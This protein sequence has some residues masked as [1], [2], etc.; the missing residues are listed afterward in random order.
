MTNYVSPCNHPESYLSGSTIESM[1]D[2]T[3]DLGLEYFACTDN[4][5][6]TSVLKAISYGK[7]KG[8]KVIPGVELFFKDNE[9]EIIQN[10]P[11]EA[12]KYFKIVVHA[13]DQEAYQEIVRQCSDQ[14][15]KRVRVGEEEYPL[16]TWKDLEQIS[17][18]NTTVSTSNVECMVSKHLLVGNGKACEAYYLKL[19]DLF[20]AENFYPAIIPFAYDKY[21]NKMMR[22]N[23]GGKVVEIPANDRVIT[24][25]KYFKNYA[26][27]LARRGHTKLK[28]VFINKVKYN[29]KKEFQDIQKVES[30]Y[31]F[32]DLP[33]DIQAQANLLIFALAKRHGDMDRLLI[34]NYAYYA[35]KDDKVVQD[36][37]LGEEKRMYQA[38]Y[39]AGIESVKEYLTVK[40]G[41][42]SE[43]LE[44]LV[45]NS[46][47][48]AKQFDN[49][50]LKYDYR[51]VDPGVEPEKQLIEIVK[52]NGR[53][54]WDDPVYLKQF[55][56]EFEL[57]T[58]NGVI[59][60]VPYFLPI[61]DVYDFYKNNGYLTGPARGC[62][63]GET[64]VYTDKG[65]K[66]LKDVEIGDK[67]ISHTGNY[68]TVLQRMRYDVSD[69]DLLHISAYYG[70]DGIKLTKDHKLL[71][72]KK[73]DMVLH[74]DGTIDY[75]KNDLNDESLRKWD[76]A[77]NF[78]VG[79]LLF[80]PWV[81]DREVKDIDFFDLGDFFTIKDDDFV[82]SKQYRY[83]RLSIRSLE[84]NYNLSRTALQ[85]C[86]KGKKNNPDHLAKIEK[87][88]LKENIS[89]EEWKDLDNC[90]FVKFKRH[91]PVNKFFCTFI[92][93]WIGDGWLTSEDN[94]FGI[95]FHT[96]EKDS[97]DCYVKYLK[98]LG[99][100][101]YENKA[102]GK[103]VVQYTIRNR[104]I[105]D[106]F[107]Y[108]F[109]NYKNSSKTKDL[110]IF[111]NLPNEKLRWIIEG[112]IGADG[113]IRKNEGS[114]YDRHC[115]DT[116]SENLKNQIKEVLMYLKIPS[117]VSTRKSYLHYEN[118]NYLCSKSFKIKFAFGDHGIKTITKDGY[119]SR[120]NKIEKTSENYVYDITVEKDSSYLTTD[121]VVHNSAGGFLI[122]YLMGITHIDP[123]K[124]GLSTSRF[125]TIDRV[126]SGNLPDI[127]CD[128]ESRV[129]LVGKDGNSGYLFEK[130]GDKAAQISTRTLLRIKSAILDANRF[131]NGGTVE[132]SIQKFSKSLP[133]T[134]QGVSDYDYVLGE[135]GLLE[136]NEDLQKYAAE[137]PE[138]WDI[139]KRALS[140]ARQHS[141]HACAYVISDTC[142]ENTVPI[143]EVGGVK[144]V[145]QPEAKQ[146]EEAGLIKYDFLVVSCLRDINLCLDYINKKHGDEGIET[147][148][149][150]DTGD[151]DLQYIWDLPE[152][153]NVFKM[154]SRGETESVFQ[155]N[156]TSVT[157]FVKKIQPQSII[158]CATITSLVRPGP[159]DFVDE[160]T[161]RNMVEEYVERKFGRSRGDI[162]IL[163][164]MLPE[165]YGI[166]CIAKGSKVKTEKR[167]L[168][169]IEHIKVGE[170]V[171]TETGDYKEVLN[172]IYK[173]K[174]E[175][176]KVRLDNSEELI[177]TPDHKVLTQKGWVKAEELTNKDLIKHFW[178][179]DEKIEEGD[180]KDWLIGMLLADGSLNN[181]TYSI[182]AGT[183]EKA[184]KIKRIADNAFNLDCHIYHHCRCWYV[185]TKSNNFSN[186]VKNEDR[187]NPLKEYCK[188]I[189]VHGL[190][191]YNK[192]FPK[193]ITKKM[194]EGFIEGDGNTKNKRIRIVNEIMARQIFRTLQSLRIKSNLFNDKGVWTVGFN[195]SKLE[196]K[197]KTKINKKE[198][199]FYIPK[200]DWKLK[201]QDNRRQHFCKSK[202][203]KTPFIN[204]DLAK[205]ISEEYGFELS[206]QS[207]SKV[208]KIEKNE[209]LDVYDLSIESIHSFVVGGNVV[210]NCY[211]EQVTKL[212]KELAGMSVIDAE[213]VRIAVG[214]KKM[215]LIQS[216]KP[217]F[218]EGASKKVGEETAT[219]IWDMMET[220]A[221]YGFNKSHAVAYSVISYACAY[222]KYHYPLEWWAAVLS[223]ADD[224][225]INEVFYK[226][227]KDMV[228]PPDINTSTEIMEVDYKEKKI[229]NKLSMI[230]GLGKSL[231]EKI[232]AGRPYADLKDFVRKKPCGPAMTKKLIHVG[233]LDSMFESTKLVDKMYEFDRV[234][235]EVDWE[236]K[237]KTKKDQLV[238]THDEKKIARLQKAIEKLSAD[239]PKEPEVDS[240]YIGITPQ[241]DYLMKKAIFPTMNLNLQAILDKESKTRLVNT[242][243]GR[244]ITNKYMKDS[245]VISGE[246]LQRIDNKILDK[247]TYFACPA[248]VVDA[249]EFTYHQ[250]KKALRLVLDS[251]GYISEKVLWADYNT[252]ELTYP[253]SLKKGAIAY[254]LYSKR[255]G[256]EYTNIQEIIVENEGVL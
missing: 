108:M 52:K 9:C 89:L 21:Y 22:V 211:Q 17:T 139:V 242:K 44:Q 141:R 81:K 64:L 46:Y 132:E 151:H 90:Y 232:I 213:N 173:G 252:G 97:A 39:M 115:I 92:G 253:K 172:N 196:Y 130:Y 149:F 166:L 217:V 188:E 70:Q 6:L 249:S 28:S 142:I 76:K 226:Y 208:L 223:N 25:S 143:M 187:K 98:E 156:T 84:K 41:L 167:G 198:K 236:N 228:L 57:L 47:N 251:S 66:E 246:A 133:T 255:E 2:K 85:N 155:L 129:P 56:E 15:K 157:P 186:K 1:I 144:R 185:S 182:A 134:P 220:F 256:S 159:L 175:T 114:R 120:I 68:R 195:Q 49:L 18:F 128:L 148:Y 78:S 174:K 138:E 243:N 5:T 96:D 58:K 42:N 50:E 215:K 203:K 169:N 59:N 221:R 4:G 135:G 206:N 107:K 238:L 112:L 45:S 125:L 19:K 225:E 73:K 82:Y 178:V 152:D 237:L 91:I 165:T 117:S 193:K 102:K 192:T 109:P 234:C 88:L 230:S 100:D 154:L 235:K 240:S 231:A 104:E 181:T 30:F 219:K 8:V 176:I 216:L 118:P 106:F 62:L 214:K 153:P 53:M 113:H 218:I 69:E 191:C 212:A 63:I 161:G 160:R 51:L 74:W 99:F 94:G 119:Y 164:E 33:S 26:K 86:K 254:F 24:D 61:V 71:G 12:I 111:K 184:E 239:G 93:R 101:L 245:M 36:M 65:V 126:Q 77:E 72:I 27:D 250:T 35:N 197:I 179:S 43:Q 177:L 116:T 11:S 3:K 23:A 222:L 171:Q 199:N 163:D 127:D 227:V 131:K 145:T 241:Q 55:K 180:E 209:V 146:C 204:Y 244:Y 205:N 170:R 31:G 122:S 194:I 103:K 190:T 224:K 75:S 189:G 54:K 29:V 95:C 105:S 247:N 123:I 183:K 162:P 121:Y 168:V 40:L 79:D 34:N 229:R 158:D 87:A 207:W 147:G 201:R 14:N 137:R 7:K 10:T 60:L 20:G 38:N 13:K 202:R 80:N 67:V 140:L 124:Y 150:C 110:G 16:F 83:N 48:F 210:H 233:V 32:S 136:K 248:Y 37:K 200:P